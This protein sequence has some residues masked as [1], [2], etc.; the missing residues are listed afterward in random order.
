M[1]GEDDVIAE[2]LEKSA[3]QYGEKTKQKKNWRGVMTETRLE[4]EIEVVF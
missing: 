1:D 4:T 3:D 2:R